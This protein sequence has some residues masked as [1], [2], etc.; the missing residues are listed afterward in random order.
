[1]AVVGLSSAGVAEADREPNT[2]MPSAGLLVSRF[3]TI[4]SLF[5]I[6]LG[7]L[8]TLDSDMVH[9]KKRRLN[10]ILHRNAADLSTSKRANAA[11]WFAA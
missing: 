4:L 1:M 8:I 11:T 3:I 2:A 10:T 5:R 7:A 9:L 6:S